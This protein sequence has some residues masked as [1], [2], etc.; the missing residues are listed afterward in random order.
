MPTNLVKE[1]EPH[2]VTAIPAAASKEQTAKEASQKPA[3]ERKCPK[4]PWMGKSATPILACGGC[5]AAPSPSM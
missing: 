1:A 5:W 2:S 4:F 3:K